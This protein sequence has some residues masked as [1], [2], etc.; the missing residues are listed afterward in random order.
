MKNNV[1]SNFLHMLNELG[2]T[3]SFFIANVGISDKTIRRMLEGKTIRKSTLEEIVKY[4]NDNGLELYPHN[5]TEEEFMNTDLSKARRLP[6][7]NA[8]I[9]GIYIC[10]YLSRRGTGSAKAMVLR[11]QEEEDLSLSVRAVDTVQYLDQANRI[12]NEILSK[13]D[14]DAAKK[15][16]KAEMEKKNSVLRSSHLLRGTVTGCGDLVSMTLSDE[17]G[18]YQMRIETSLSSYLNTYKAAS[19]W[20]SWRGGAAIASVYDIEAWPYS[21]VI[22]MIGSEHWNPA[23]MTNE[24][25]GGVL[26]KMHAYQ[27][28]HNMLCLHKEID[29]LWYEVFMEAARQGTS[30]RKSR[31]IYLTC[32]NC[33]NVVKQNCSRSD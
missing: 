21:M 4:Y 24:Y 25:V 10:P 9:K 31:Q 19:T 15:A 7:E 11:I 26:E 12:I 32:G 30:R 20:Y 18:T 27:K 22:G 29:E 2:Q 17:S 8:Q 3:R 1:A 23:V 28:K 6:W 33:P 14:W 16:F 5:V 13:E